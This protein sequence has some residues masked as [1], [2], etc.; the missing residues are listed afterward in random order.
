MFTQE[1]LSVL[2]HGEKKR[3]RSKPEE[4]QIFNS[5]P[6]Y[7]NLRSFALGE[8][9]ALR[10]DCR[11]LTQLIHKGMASWI[12]SLEDCISRPIVRNKRQ[13][14]EVKKGGKQVEITD[15][16][17]NSELVMVLSNMVLKNQQEVKFS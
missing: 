14:L 15:E 12:E 8:P 1:V 11:G 16:D 5:I 13:N 3:Q 9:N 7:E 6:H 2:Y 4:G 10:N 17:L